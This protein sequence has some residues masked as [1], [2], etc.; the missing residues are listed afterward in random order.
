MIA[1]SD[2]Y[3]HERCSNT[4]IIVFCGTCRQIA[5]AGH[6]FVVRQGATL[7]FDIETQNGHAIQTLIFAKDVSSFALQFCND[8]G[9]VILC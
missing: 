5:Y 1:R 9:H 8:Y 2:I 3:Q 6:K 7:T 4:W